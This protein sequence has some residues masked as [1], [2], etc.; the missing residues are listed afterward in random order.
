MISMGVFI[1]DILEQK[2]LI[3]YYLTKNINDDVEFVEVSKTL[4]EL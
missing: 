1:W 4:I 3:L 2:N